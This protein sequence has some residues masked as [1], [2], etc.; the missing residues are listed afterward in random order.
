MRP[1]TAAAAAIA[2][3]IEVRARALALPA[4]EVA[5]GGR[6]AA[7]A[8]RARGRRS[9]RR[10]SSSPRSR[11]SKPA[12]RKMRSSPS[13]SACALHAGPSPARPS[14]APRALRP[15][16]TAAAARR[17]SMRL[18]VQEPMK[19]RS[20]A[21]SLERCAGREAHVVERA[22]ACCRGAA[23]G[24]RRGRAPRRRWAARP[25]GWCPRS[26][27]ARCAARVERDL[28][29]ERRVVVGR[30]SVRQSASARVPVAP[31][32]AYGRPS[33]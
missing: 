9:C 10:T 2:G 24:S 22:L 4:L 28:A 12:S 14:R 1:V 11:H 6:G 17:S 5:V 33:R 30:G 27:S 18:L 29:V 32:G 16:R 3:L 7:L 23:S 20:I 26:P 15:A 13:A 19:T 8:R 25:P 31:C 21:M